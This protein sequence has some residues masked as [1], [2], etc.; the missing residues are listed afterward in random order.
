LANLLLRQRLDVAT[1]VGYVIQA[2]RALG[3]AH[4][5][6]TVHRDVNPAHL[7]LSRQGLIKVIGWGKAWRLGSSAVAPYEGAGRMIG[8]PGFMAPEQFVDSCQVDER[9]D[10]YG[11]GCTLYAL[12]AS[13][14]LL[15]PDWRNE[16]TVEPAETNAPPLKSVRPEA[17]DALEAVY[18][19]M[20]AH[21]PKDRWASMPQVIEALERTI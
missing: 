8:T 4:Q 10:V 21:A 7:M 3:H 20:L 19:K 17:P 18:Q 14:S 16:G 12:L 15:P 5:R 11:L 9:T 2:A 6:Q 1:A 13:Q